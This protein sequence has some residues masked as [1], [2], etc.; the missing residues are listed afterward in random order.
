MITMI[1][2]DCPSLGLLLLPSQSVRRVFRCPVSVL[3]AVLSIHLL[4]IVIIII[5]NNNLK[6]LLSSKWLV[7]ISPIQFIIHIPPTISETVYLNYLK[8]EVRIVLYQVPLQIKLHV[9]RTNS[10]RDIDLRSWPKKNQIFFYWGTFYD[11]RLM[12]DDDS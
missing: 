2:N 3:P 12:I 11:D 1:I 4:L 8:F 6:H 9:I 10:F 7:K 5:I